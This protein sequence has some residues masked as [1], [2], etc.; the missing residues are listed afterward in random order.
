MAT[1]TVRFADREKSFGFLS[2]TSGR[3]LF[4]HRTDC[5]PDTFERLDTNTKVSYDE[6]GKPKGPRATNVALVDE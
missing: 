6:I 4:F 1:G 5:A 3:S 2:S